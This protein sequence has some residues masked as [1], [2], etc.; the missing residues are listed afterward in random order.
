[1]LAL[2]YLE[3]RPVKVVV[4]EVEVAQRTISCAAS[5]TCPAAA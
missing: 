4:V 2:H 5:A 3:D 1:M